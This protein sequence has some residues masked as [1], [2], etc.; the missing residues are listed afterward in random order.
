MKWKKKT[1]TNKEV[2][3]KSESVPMPRAKQSHVLLSF[4]FTEA[5]LCVEQHDPNFPSLLIEHKLDKVFLR[6]SVSSPHAHSN[7][8]AKTSE[9]RSMGVL[10]RRIG[11]SNGPLLIFLKFVWMRVDDEEENFIL[12]TDNSGRKTGMVLVKRINNFLKVFS[13][14]A[15]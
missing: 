13:G 6:P 10:F 4:K 7:V 9:T 14:K 12:M 3:F 11:E 15:Y 5:V 8:E 1:K 2:T